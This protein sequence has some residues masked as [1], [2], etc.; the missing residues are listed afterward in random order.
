LT[1]TENDYRRDPADRKLI[2]SR[3]LL[4]NLRRL[5]AL[6]LGTAVLT[7][8]F[9]GCSFLLE[10]S[11]IS[12]GK[13]RLDAIEHLKDLFWAVFLLY[14]VLIALFFLFGRHIGFT[15]MAWISLGFAMLITVVFGAL[16]AVNLLCVI[17]IRALRRLKGPRARP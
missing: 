12:M 15:V 11:A 4:S 3:I 5:Q 6:L 2:E 9:L 13:L 1:P 17:L 10:D 8:L 16:L 14:L 7:A